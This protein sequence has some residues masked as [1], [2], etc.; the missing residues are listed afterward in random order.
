MFSSQCIFIV[1]WTP[2]LLLVNENETIYEKLSQKIVFE[3]DFKIAEV[4]LYSNIQ[5][6][7]ILQKDSKVFSFL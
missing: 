5:I 3:G 1:K 6:C 7:S 2:S 4:T